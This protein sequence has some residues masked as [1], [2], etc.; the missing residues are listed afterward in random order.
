MPGLVDDAGV[1][2]TALYLTP[3]PPSPPIPL[4]NTKSRKY[5]SGKTKMMSKDYKKYQK[6][7]AAPYP[8]DCPIWIGMDWQG[9]ANWLSIG[10]SVEDWSIIG[11]GLAW[12][13]LK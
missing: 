12:I 5:E 9:L 4:D 11:P 10:F 8:N 13:G 1:A 2:R 6:M 3:L 7:R